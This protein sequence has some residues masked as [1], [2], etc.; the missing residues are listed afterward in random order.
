MNAT[1]WQMLSDLL[2]VSVGDVGYEIRRM[3]AERAPHHTGAKFIATHSLG[4]VVSRYVFCTFYNPKNVEL[5]SQK[6]VELEFFASQ[7]MVELKDFCNPNNV[8]DLGTLR[9][10]LTYAFCSNW[11]AKITRIQTAPRIGLVEGNPF[12]RTDLDPCG[13]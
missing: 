10:N 12:L 2:H 1:L 4:M 6:M 8:R 13:W 5:T 3:L 11:A 9:S 7:K